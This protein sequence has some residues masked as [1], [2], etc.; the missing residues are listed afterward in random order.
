MVTKRQ[1]YRSDIDGLRA[2]AVLAIVIFHGFPDLLPGG[3][4]GVDIF[5]VI[6]GFL[7]SNILLTDLAHGQFS[8]QDFY[9]SRIRR[10][11]PA[12]ILVLVVTLIIGWF[13]LL[14]GEFKNLGINAAAAAVFSANLLQWRQIGYFDPGAD[15]KPLLHL[16]SL[17]VE[18]QFYLA[19]PLTLALLWRSQKILVLLL[20]GLAVSFSANALLVYSY[21]IA[22]FYCPLTR[23]WELLIGALL[24]YVGLF[25]V[26]LGSIYSPRGATVVSGIG[27]AL[28]AVGIVVPNPAAAFPGWLALLPTVGT[29]LVISA[30][31]HSWVNSAVLGRQFLVRIGLISYALYLWHWPLLTFLRIWDVEIPS[32]ASRAGMI[33]LSF[34]LAWL[35][36]YF[37]ERPIRRG[38][39]SR[40]AAIPAGVIMAAIAVFGFQ[41]YRHD[42]LKD[43]AYAQRAQKLFSLDDEA[44][45]LANYK[46]ESCDGM[47]GVLPRV[48]RYCTTY[49]SP[50][51]ADTIVVWGDSHADAWAPAFYR[52]A[53]HHRLR[54]VFFTHYACPPLLGVRQSQVLDNDCD[55]LQLGG[56][57]LESIK[58]LMPARIVLLARWS[59]YAN[60]WH[61]D[62]VLQEAQTHFLTTDPIGQADLQTSRQAIARQLPQTVLA[63]TTVAP[64]L[65]FHTVPVLKLDV[66]TGVARR[67]NEFEP[68]LDEH[69]RFESFTSSIISDLV[70]SNKNVAEFDPANLM[71]QST[72]SAFH[73]G[74][75][76]YRDD[77]HLSV[78]GALLFEDLLWKALNERKLGAPLHNGNS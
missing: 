11:F 66:K 20:V 53:D 58:A 1:P 55:D 3:F 37:I 39:S 14:A 62:G 27:V 78:Q 56:H 46:T 50:S 44:T 16:W 26:D 8:F 60:G 64:V 71:C 9:T 10:I 5:F 41:I 45:L 18:E 15:A 23:I 57:F 40:A 74:V 69:R 33:A 42:G 31:A 25:R 6:S 72:C 43:R 2:V 67:P 65:I 12:L 47:S 51:A 48:R 73:A 49:G 28:I 61:K 35:T 29:A 30:G 63:L 54:I 38:L 75:P 17:G 76:M 59:V 36:T 68:T 24:S 4:V 32:A 19:W 13:I 52:L 34:A 77:N 21:P 7:I 22:V 70:A